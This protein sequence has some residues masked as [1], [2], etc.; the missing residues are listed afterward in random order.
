LAL[1]AARPGVELLSVDSMQVYRGMD[2]GTAKPTPTERD[3]VRHHLI[4]VAEV[5]ERFTVARFVTAAASVLSD[6]EARD[7]TAV[8]VGGTG[9][10]LQAVLG[11]LTPP[12]DWP[13]VRS[14]LDAETTDTL[15][16]RL[17]ELDAA[18]AHRIEPGNRRR[19]LR[20]LE[21]TSGGGRPFSS[22]GPGVGAYPPTPRFS[23]VGIWLPRSAVAERVA[24]RVAAMIDAGLVAEVGRLAPSMGA[25]A[26]QALGYKEILAHLERGVPL[27][28][29]VQETVRRTRQFSRRQ[30]SWFRRDPRV[31]WHGTAQEPRHLVPGLLAELDRVR[32]GR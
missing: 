12:G 24:R 14:D 25:T 32:A 18:A 27:E 3:A 5:G 6:I 16:Q 7:G 10:Y 2:I 30:R 1:A 28:D 9:L 11:D 4:D 20:A 21:V 23:L 13:D 17:T 15:W 22:Y 26:R 29:C 31:R 19:L 8:L